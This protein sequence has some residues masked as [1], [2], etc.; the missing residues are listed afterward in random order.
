MEFAMLA[1]IR[2][3]SSRGAQ[4]FA[5]SI[6]ALYASAK[7]PCRIAV[8]IDAFRQGIAN[9]HH[10]GNQ[11]IRRCQPSPIRSVNP[12]RPYDDPIHN[13]RPENSDPFRSH[14]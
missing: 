11:R 13:P 3:A 1:A 7:P 5:W 10:Y 9:H 4:G 8:R 14:S 6:T 2:R 12:P